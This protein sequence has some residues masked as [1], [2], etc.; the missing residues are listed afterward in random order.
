[1]TNRLPSLLLFSCWIGLSLF[2]FSFCAS[3]EPEEVQRTL[4]RALGKRVELVLIECEI[5]PRS[6]FVVKK[7]EDGFCLFTC[8]D[9][10]HSASLLQAINLPI[11]RILTVREVSEGIF[12]LTAL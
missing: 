9:S 11:E 10:T 6:T 12:K 7:I 8:E 3:D 4:Q 2:N 1:M 5:K